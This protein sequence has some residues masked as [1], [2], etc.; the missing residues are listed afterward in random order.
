MHRSG[1]ASNLSPPR[2]ED[3]RIGGRAMGRA[4]PGT[5]AIYE[6]SYVAAWTSDS[7]FILTEDAAVLSQRQ[8]P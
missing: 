6:I 1:R 5:A 7:S 4:N 2:H 3:K 8:Q